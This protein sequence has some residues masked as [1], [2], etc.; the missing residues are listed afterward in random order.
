MPP[1][2]TRFDLPLF[3]MN[4][5]PKLS[6]LLNCYS[7]NNDMPNLYQ[8]Y[9]QHFSGDLYRPHQHH[10][11]LISRHRQILAKSQLQ[12]EDLMKA[13]HLPEMSTTTSSYTLPCASLTPIPLGTPSTPCGRMESIEAHVTPDIHSQLC[14]HHS[15]H[16]LDY[17]DIP[18]AYPGYKVQSRSSPRFFSRIIRT[19]ARNF[20][21]DERDRK[22]Y[23]DMYSCMP[24]PLFILTI[25][26]I[27]V[28]ASSR[29]MLVITI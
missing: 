14:S 29:F 3:Q 18:H 15:I 24:P 1:R 21:S 17:D 22:Y 19:V 23:A 6:H 13:S 2:L 16:L 10:E 11:D 5:K 26:F 8:E 20:L 12:S 27:E 4:E 7:T 28:S 25:T 9:F